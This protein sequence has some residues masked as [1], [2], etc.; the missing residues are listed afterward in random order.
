MVARAKSRAGGAGYH[1]SL[2]RR[3]PVA[4]TGSAPDWQSGGQGFESPRVHQS[5][6]YANPCR[7]NT[8]L[9]VGDLAVHDHLDEHAPVDGFLLC[10]VPPRHY[11]EY[12]ASRVAPATTGR[13]R[14][15]AIRPAS[16][17]R[18]RQSGSRLATTTAAA[19][20]SSAGSV[21]ITLLPSVNPINDAA[22]VGRATPAATPERTAFDDPAAPGSWS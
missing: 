15:V 14:V 5:S 9:G 12:G 8:V 21:T 1:H 19:G 4:Q 10:G 17:H 20:S 22:V 2:R 18:K 6:H 3:G 7:G 11:S 13:P 16:R